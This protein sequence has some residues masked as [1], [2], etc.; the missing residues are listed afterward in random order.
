M[1]LIPGALTMHATFW[2]DNRLHV[3]CA[4]LSNV[5][6]ATLRA[7]CVILS[8]HF[9]AVLART[10]TPDIRAFR[11]EAPVCCVYCVRIS[12]W[13]QTKTNEK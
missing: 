8:H 13:N 5:T 10:Q 2:R 12:A 1:D 4:Q 11:L 7:A 6:D 3:P 9:I